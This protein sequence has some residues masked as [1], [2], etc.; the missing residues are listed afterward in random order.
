MMACPYGIPRYDW[1]E[2]VPYIRKCILCYDRI[3]IGQAARLHGSVSDEG[4]NFRKSQRP[5]G[6][7]S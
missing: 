7:S 6:G 3:K 5:S 1:A 2:A 4:D